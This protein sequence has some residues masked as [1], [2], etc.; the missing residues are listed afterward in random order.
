LA[1][2]SGCSV[3]GGGV[4]VGVGGGVCC[5]DDDPTATVLGVPDGDALSCWLTSEEE[6]A[7][8]NT[9]GTTTSDSRRGMGVTLAVGI[10]GATA[11]GLG[12]GGLIP[13]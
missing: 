2:L 6:Q 4:G 12:P 10:C 9:T 1:T 11:A 8:K 5:G 13:E 3:A 7:A